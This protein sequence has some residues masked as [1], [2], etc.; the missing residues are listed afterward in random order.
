MPE[1]DRD[2]AGASVGPE[3]AARLILDS[4]GS[5]VVAVDRHGR[6][7]FWNAR[8]SRLF[9]YP[10]EEAI[11]QPADDLLGVPRAPGAPSAWVA[12]LTGG[13]HQVAIA[14]LRRRDG[15][16]LSV[17]LSLS[18]LRNSAG[19]L[20]GVV[21]LCEDLAESRSLLEPELERL[22]GGSPQLVCVCDAQARVRVGAPALAAALGLPQSD[23][24]QATLWEFV[25]P[26]HLAAARA[27]WAKALGPAGTAG[28]GEV[29]LRDAT[30]ARRWFEVR[31]HDQRSDPL[32]AGVVVTARD[33]TDRRAAQ[34]QLVAV[35]SCQR[36]VLGAIREGVWLLDQAGSTTYASRRARELLQLP[37][38]ERS[39]RGV[40]AARMLAEL[41]AEAA[42]TAQHVIAAAAAGQPGEAD[43]PRGPG[44][45]SGPWLRLVGHPVRRPG[46]PARVLVVLEEVGE[47]RAGGSRPEPWPTFDPVTGLATRLLLADDLAAALEERDRAGGLVGVLFIAIDHFAEVNA[48]AGHAAGDAVLRTA[49]QRI[50]AALPA[51]A[52]L[53][54]FGADTFVA[55]LPGLATHDSALTVAGEVHRRLAEP[56]PAGEHR[57]RLTASIGVVASATAPAEA[58]VR[59]ADAALTAAKAAG[60]DRVL[61]YHAGIERPR[62]DRLGIA[63]A[64]AAEQAPEALRLSYRPVVDVGPGRVVALAAILTYH[65]G[66]GPAYGGAAVLTTARAAG[67]GA[68]VSQ[69]L[70]RAACVQ[71]R[72]HGLPV[73]VQV[74]LDD[75]LDG[76]LG[77]RVAQVL[78][79]TGCPAELLICEVTQPNVLSRPEAAIAALDDL[80]SRGVAL[81][82]SGFGVGEVSLAQ[83]REL[84]V[85]ILRLEQAFL[86]GPEYDDSDLELVRAILDIADA[87]G[88]QVVADG[89]SSRDQL[90]LLAEVG[91]AFAAGEFVSPDLSAEGLAGALDHLAAHPPR[92]PPHRAGLRR[93]DPGVP[94]RRRALAE[95]DAQLIRQMREAGHSPHTIAAALNAQGRRTPEGS[96]W[97]AVSVARVA[98][99]TAPRS[100]RLGRRGPPETPEPGQ[101]APGA[102]LPE[103]P[104]RSPGRPERRTSEPG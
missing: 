51:Q 44:Q 63:R 56:C 35:E 93:R 80:R 62:R 17:R 6:V 97:H 72:A 53:A 47:R 66:E 69:R 34:S 26:E 55:V 84:P 70:L 45:A 103:A 83:L 96:R 29:A 71:A 64:L 30:G 73:G 31:L 28:P 101:V 12:G 40:P 50:A 61:A 7:S 88:L 76:G 100:R 58:L 75:L 90:C 74:L 2:N 9:G 46:H 57:L 3:P 33:V 11:G 54:R 92:V 78:Q 79:E 32:I 95:P 86:P 85:D 5:A 19:L 94:R 38:P 43:V 98:A 14:R 18:P 20:A 81:A 21:G 25:V 27:A 16:A 8:A 68:S 24:P 10:P 60:R 59:D 22:L 67:V 49:A 87:L 104:E 89:V 77:E 42:R 39:R 13:A 82:V 1:S 4:L 41:P 65:P 23:A 91:C 102:P 15:S 36:A 37:E 48:T 52:S 99:G